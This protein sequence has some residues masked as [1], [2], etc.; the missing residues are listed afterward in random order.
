MAATSGSGIRRSSCTLASRTEEGAELVVGEAGVALASLDYGAVGAAARRIQLPYGEDVALSVQ[1]VSFACGGFTVAWC[2]HDVLVDGKSLSF[3]DSARSELARSGTG[4]LAVGSQPSHDRSVFRPRA[5]PTYSAALDEAFTPLDAKR[6]INALTANQSFVERL[7]YIEAS[8][9]ER[10][11]RPASRE[12]DGPRAT[13]VQAVSAYLWKALAGVVGTAD[14]CCRMG[15]RVKGC[16]RIADPERRAAMRS[17]VGNFMTYMVEE[18]SVEEVLRMPLP[19][20]AAMA[21]EA[22]AAPAPYEEHFQELVDWVEDHKPRRYVETAILGLGS[23]ILSVTTL[24]S[25]RTDTYFGFGHAAIAVPMA[26]ATARLCSGY[27]QVF[28]CPRDDG[29]WFVNV[30][31]WPQ[32]AAALKADEPRVLDQ[33]RDGGASDSSIKPHVLA[34][35]NLDL[36]PLTVQGSLFV[37][38]PKPPTAD[39]DAV[40]PAFEAGLPSLLNHFFPFAGRIVTDRISGLRPEISRLRPWL[41]HCAC[42]R[43]IQLPFGEDMA[44]SVQAMSFACGGFTV[45][46]S[47]NHVLVDASAMSLLVGAW[48]ELM[49]SGALAAGSQPNHDRSIFRPRAPP[50]YGAALDETFTPLD[51]RRQVNA[52]TTEQSFVQRMYYIE[53]SD[54]ARLQ[55]M[56]SRDDGTRTTCVQAV[57]A[58]LWKVLARVVGTADTGCRMGWWVNGRQRLTAP[59]LCS[60]MRNYVGNVVTFVAREASVTEVVGM[61]LPDVA[62]MVRK[63]ITAPAYDEHFQELVDWVEDHKT[64][65]YVETPSLG[66]GSPT[67]ASPTDTNFGFGRAV[68]VMATSTLTERLCSGFVQTVASPRADGSWFAN[69]VVWPRLAAALESDEPRVFKPVT[70]EYLGLLAPQVRHSRL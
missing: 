12:L 27:V 32:L 16:T 62:P 54:I 20:V 6:Q 48:S 49:R 50:S 18:A 36:V 41:R 68:L 1:V 5:P 33:A 43:K 10:L 23:P 21:R 26:T 70:A 46:W 51:A 9:I 2:T 37:I 8:D 31:V 52:L 61:P 69:A 59:A 47:T 19:D 42:L 60:A 44:L 67:V 14:P 30:L 24:S 22:I 13:R 35:S 38:Y 17:Y 53:A 34:V 55:E 63:A 11:R 66:L 28:S 45:A 64:E 7:Y 3:L 57:S 65:R 39:F 29:T 40:V 56:A 58:Y 25:F 15:W 4:T